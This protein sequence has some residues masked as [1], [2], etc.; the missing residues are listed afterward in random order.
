[1]AIIRAI[2]NDF[3]KDYYC[4]KKLIKDKHFR[5]ESGTRIGI[6][7]RYSK[8]NFGT[9]LKEYWLWY[10][11]IF[12]AFC[13]G[14]LIASQYYKGKCGILVQNV[15]ETCKSMNYGLIK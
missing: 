7:F 12:F 4:I 8:N 13:C 9:L 11:I 1:M 10:L 15:V 6:F 2:I 5:K 3:K 14:F